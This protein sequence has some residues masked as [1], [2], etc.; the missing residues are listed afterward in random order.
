MVVFGKSYKG[1]SGHIGRQRLGV[2]ET[3]PFLQ[4][5]TY[6]LVHCIERL[7]R[8]L[9]LIEALIH[10]VYAADVRAI[11]VNRAEVL[12]LVEMLADAVC[13]GHRLAPDGMA[14]QPTTA[15]AAFTGE[16][17]KTP[18][19]AALSAREGRFRTSVL[20][21]LPTFFWMLP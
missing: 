8:H 1:R 16:H 6:V 11:F 17:L 10:E 3:V 18:S 12:L 21:A 5:A 4:L 9:I 14:D 20:S 7:P 2:M 13:I 15:A 19:L